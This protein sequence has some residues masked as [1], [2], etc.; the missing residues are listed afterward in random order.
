MGGFD[1]GKR[2]LLLGRLG[3]HR[4]HGDAS[5][6]IFF[7]L[8]LGFLDYQIWG[9]PQ[10]LTGRRW[11]ADFGSDSGWLGMWQRPLLMLRRMLYMEVPW[12]HIL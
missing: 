3:R 10:T 7:G 2:A 8:F 11:L 12:R 9:G 1:V 6:G 4:S 5:G